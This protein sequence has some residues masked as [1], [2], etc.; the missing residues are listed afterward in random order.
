MEQIVCLSTSNFHPYPTRKQNVMR[1][2]PNAEILYFDPPVSYIAPL[3]DKKARERL[4]KYRGPGERAGENITVYALPPVLPFGQKFRLINRLNQRRLAR[5]IRRRMRQHGYAKPLLW[6]YSPTSADILAHLPHRGLV[7]DCVDRHSAYRG[8]LD[9]GLV[10]A[11]ERDLARQADVVFCTAQ[12]LYQ[13]LREYN[14]RTYLI[15]NGADYQLFSQAAGPNPGH[16]PAHPV[17][18]FVGMLQD[19][20]A[21]DC[22]LAL[23]DAYPEGEIRLIGRLMPGVDIAALQMRKNIRLLGLLPQSEL[24]RQMRDFDVCLN[25]FDPGKLS[26]DVSPLKFYEYLAT[27][28]SVVST[29]EPRQVA[30]YADLIYI[31]DSPGDFVVKCTMALAEDDP[32]KTRGRQAAGLAASWDNRVGQ[33]VEKLQETAI[34]TQQTEVIHENHQ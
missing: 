30:D 16:D 34:L 29:R 27:G 24:P 33:M 26:Q 19:C 12:G 10:D 25:I 5:Y 6:C 18:G 7:Y 8:L 22:L 23:A 14:R 20:L 21:Y 17:F 13:T 15:P 2:L 9:P 11:M 3:K 4:N 1:R 31:A 28:K 32:D